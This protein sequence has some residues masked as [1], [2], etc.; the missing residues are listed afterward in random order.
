MILSKAVSAQIHVNNTDVFANVGNVQYNTTHPMEFSNLIVDDTYLILNTS[1]FCITSSNNINIS[2]NFLDCCMICSEVGRKLIE[3]YANTSSGNVFFNISGFENS[4]NYSIYRDNTL[5]ANVTSNATGYVSFNNSLWGKTYKFTINCSTLILQIYN[6]SPSDLATNVNYNINGVQTCVNISYANFSGHHVNYTFWSNSSGTWQPYGNG[7][8]T[9]N[10]T[11]C[12]NNSNFSEPC[13][14][15]YWRVIATDGTVTAN[16]TYSFE[17]VCPGLF[18]I[19]CIMQPSGLSLG[20]LALGSIPIFYILFKREG[21]K[22]ITYQWENEY[23]K[24]GEKR[25]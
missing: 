6:P 25:T 12:D 9:A 24:K 10:G 18:L 16:V 21:K 8:A 14:I 15:Y 1:R 7:T 20:L 17:T 5:Y 23:M 13:T 4:L 19:A 3:F 11:Y 22:K 2:L